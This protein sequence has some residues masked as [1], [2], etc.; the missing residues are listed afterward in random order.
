MRFL[1]ILVSLATFSLPSFAG[2]IW[3]CYTRP[4]TTSFVFE[5]VEDLN[6]ITV[7]HHNGVE[8]MPIHSGTIT[9]YDLKRLKE[10]GE[11]LQK[12]GTQLSFR[13]D[14]ENCKDYGDL[15]ISCFTK[16]N[17]TINGIEVKSAFLTTS[18]VKTQIFNSKFDEL[19]VHLSLGIGN[20]SY[21]IPMT[22]Q[23]TDCSTGQETIRN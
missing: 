17:E 7:Y 13:F 3:S 20:T 16:V 4:L 2:T 10:Q 11:I 21:D 23:K 9:P 8:F 22:Y 6:Q 1:A 15:R 12:L 14:P 5:S 19:K 18:T